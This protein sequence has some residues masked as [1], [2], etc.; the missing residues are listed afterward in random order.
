MSEINILTT[1]YVYNSTIN[2]SKTKKR[3]IDKIRN[4]L[5]SKLSNINKQSASVTMY[6]E[7]AYL[8]LTLFDACRSYKFH[9]KSLVFYETSIFVVHLI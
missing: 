4:K 8:M 9:N 5:E 6:F 7:I 1:V 2:T 3:L